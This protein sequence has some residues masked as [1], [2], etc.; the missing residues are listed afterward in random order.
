MHARLQLQDASPAEW[1]WNPRKLVHYYT[2]DSEWLV[3]WRRRKMIRLFVV[4]RC[5]SRRSWSTENSKSIFVLPGLADAS[6][7]H[8]ILVPI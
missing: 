8:L 1:E 3:G 2:P 7:D 5:R 4:A 6:Q